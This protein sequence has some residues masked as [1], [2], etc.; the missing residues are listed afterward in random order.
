MTHPGMSPEFAE[1]KELEPG[2]YEAPLEFTMAGDW[3]I[4]YHVT[5]QSG[6]KLDRQIDVRGV[7]AN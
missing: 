6:E 3:L 7:R 2:R 5:L 4:I 1:A